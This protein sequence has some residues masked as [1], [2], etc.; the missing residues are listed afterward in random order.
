VGALPVAYSLSSSQLGAMPLDPV[1]VKEIFLTASQSLLGVVALASFSF[2]LRE[3]TLLFV[4]FSTQLL[5]QLLPHMF[6]QAF[7]ELPAFAF[8]AGYLF[9]YAYLVFSVLFLAVSRKSRSG[10]FGLLRLSIQAP[11]LGE[12]GGSVPSPDRENPS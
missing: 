9:A 12:V 1:Q 8:R 6:P 5:T 4:L 7:A 2:S 11:V 3:G 10:F